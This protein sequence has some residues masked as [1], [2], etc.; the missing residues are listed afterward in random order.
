MF[1]IYTT[2]ETVPPNTINEILQEFE[3]K[4]AVFN[5][6]RHFFSET[7]TLLMDEKDSYFGVVQ[8]VHEWCGYEI[9]LLTAYKK[10]N[11]SANRR[12]VLLTILRNRIAKMNEVQIKLN[13]IPLTMKKAA[14]K[15][16]T[17]QDLL[18]NKSDEQSKSV[19]RFAETTNRVY[20]GIIV[21]NEKI[22]NQI[23]TIKNLKVQIE[24]SEFN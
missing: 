6:D 5:E 3:T 18:K 21:I 13:K 22:N 19:Q 7:V 11:Y 24:G 1:W 9:P 15:M 10:I 17:L 12:A 16:T 8:N 23:E 14:G 20:T 4:M 2:T